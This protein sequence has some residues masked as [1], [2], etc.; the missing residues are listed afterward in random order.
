MWLFSGVAESGTSVIGCASDAASVSVGGAAPDEIC[1]ADN[2]D[3]IELRTEKGAG[4]DVFETARFLFVRT[5][6]DGDSG[7]LDTVKVKTQLPTTLPDREFL[8][9][10]NPGSLVSPNPIVIGQK[11]SIS[12][13]LQNKDVIFVV[14]G[15][16][17]HDVVIDTRPSLPGYN[18][19]NVVVVADR[20]D[21]L[22]ITASGYNGRSGRDAKELLALKAAS[23]DSSVPRGIADKFMSRMAAAPAITSLMFDQK[24]DM[25]NYA[26][27]GLQ[28][29]AGETP[30]GGSGTYAYEVLKGGTGTADIDIPVTAFKKE[31]SKRTYCTRDAE[32][33]IRQQCE[34]EAEYSFRALCEIT[35]ET[36]DV[37]VMK[38]DR[39]T[40]ER[41]VCGTDVVN[42]IRRKIVRTAYITA[43]IPGVKSFSG[44]VS[45]EVP[46]ADTWKIYRPYDA[47]KDVGGN[48]AVPIVEAGI[49]WVS[50]FWYQSASIG[51]GSTIP[52]ASS[53]S[54]GNDYNTATGD[55]TNWTNYPAD[56]GSTP[57]ASKLLLVPRTYTKTESGGG[58][59]YTPP[60]G[61]IT[62]QESLY[63]FFSNSASN[64]V[65][66]YNGS[67]ATD[68]GRTQTGCAKLLDISSIKLVAGDILSTKIAGNTALKLAGATDYSRAL[69]Y[70][71]SFDAKDIG[72]SNADL[73]KAVVTVTSCSSYEVVEAIIG[74]NPTRSGWANKNKAQSAT[75]SVGRIIGLETFFQYDVA[76]SCYVSDPNSPPD[77]LMSSYGVS[78]ANDLSVSS[79]NSS[80]WHKGMSTGSAP[81][82]FTTPSPYD[83]AKN[84]PLSKAGFDIAK[85]FVPPPGYP[86]AT[87]DA[88]A[89]LQDFCVPLTNFAPSGNL[90]G[91]R[92]ANETSAVQTFR[93]VILPVYQTDPVTGVASPSSSQKRTCPG[94]VRLD[95]WVAAV[96]R[97]SC[98]G[99]TDN[100]II[101]SDWSSTDS[102]DNWQTWTEKNGGFIPPVTTDNTY[103]KIASITET[104]YDDMPSVYTNWSHETDNALF[105]TDSSTGVN[106]PSDNNFP[107]IDQAYDSDGVAISSVKARSYPGWA[108]ESK[109]KTSTNTIL[110]PETF[111]PFGG[112]PDEAKKKWCNAPAYVSVD[113]KL[114]K[115]FGAKGALIDPPRHVFSFDLVPVTGGDIGSPSRGTPVSYTG[116]EITGVVASGSAGAQEGFYATDSIFGGA[117]S[118]AALDFKN[119]DSATLAWRAKMF[120]IANYPL[121]RRAISEPCG[122]GKVFNQF[123][124]YCH[125]VS[126]YMVAGSRGV[127]IYDENRT[128]A[129]NAFRFTYDSQSMAGNRPILSSTSGGTTTTKTK[130]HLC[131]NGVGGSTN[132]TA[133]M[134]LPSGPE[135]WWFLGLF[136]PLSVMTN[137]LEA[138]L[139]K[140]WA[141]RPES[142]GKTVASP[143]FALTYADIF[144]SS[145]QQTMRILAVPQ[146]RLAANEVD[147]SPTS[148][149]PKLP[150]ESIFLQIDFLPDAG[151]TFVKPNIAIVRRT[152]DVGGVTTT[153]SLLDQSGIQT[154]Q[155]TVEADGKLTL[156]LGNTSSALYYKIENISSTIVA[157]MRS[158]TGKE[159][160]TF[161]TLSAPQT[162]NRQDDWNLS[163]RTV[164]GYSAPLSWK[165]SIF[166]TKTAAT[167]SVSNPPPSC[168]LENL[169]DGEFKVEVPLQTITNGGTNKSCLVPGNYCAMTDEELSLFT[170]SKTSSKELIATRPAISQFTPWSHELTSAW[171][172][173]QAFNTQSDFGD[174]TPTESSYGSSVPDCS[175]FESP[176]D[177]YLDKNF[178]TMPRATDP[179]KTFETRADGKTFDLYIGPAGTASNPTGNP[180]GQTPLFKVASNA[181][182][183][184]SDACVEWDNINASRCV[185]FDSTFSSTAPAGATL[186]FGGLPGS[187]RRVFVETKTRL[188]QNCTYFD[189][190]NANQCYFKDQSVTGGSCP[191]GTSLSGT[192]CSGAAAKGTPVTARC[193]TSSCIFP[194]NR[195][196]YQVDSSVAVNGEA[197]EDGSNG[198]S[199]T[200]FCRDCPS[201]TSENPG[202]GAQRANT[203]WTGAGLGGRGTTPVGSARSLT[204][205]CVSSDNNNINP[206]FQ[207]RNLWSQPFVPGAS[208]QNGRNGLPGSGVTTYKDLT[209]EVIWQI[210]QPDFWFGSDQ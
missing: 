5:H 142:F 113:G 116:V 48:P 129:Q 65:S 29:A 24:L 202:S 143:G 166:T 2:E 172:K 107:G 191:A 164:T 41:A 209:P 136:R 132:C 57:R 174:W 17:V 120:D 1:K 121:L 50:P 151:E 199:I 19:G 186:A 183:R 77:W 139:Q 161:R 20:L 156:I 128:L 104:R 45:R 64:D 196:T 157:G 105:V 38:K 31:E 7:N 11:A 30:V 208:G 56:F 96:T 190:A 108:R 131:L 8:Q 86:S 100:G 83:A 118:K 94:G 6:G 162:R 188:S 27:A 210:S 160:L 37:T 22:A 91:T 148:Q 36:R 49:N 171:A 125:D 89:N 178:A 80:L 187:W 73:K 195:Q 53:L 97:P 59:D 180:N 74:S 46:M 106:F 90:A 3:G 75:C 95:R 150:V 14:D 126:S 181:D 58:V 159:K 138:S 153:E 52:V 189:P 78:Q 122:A 167:T 205:T 16:P 13:G 51:S 47:N 68:A 133:S 35:P 201:L 163:P 33:K 79:L 102:A 134:D 140:Q 69:D 10:Q 168:S 111:I 182:L 114:A 173:D 165:S 44:L 93:S 169:A 63:G 42:Q 200:V 192:M 55:L 130:Y 124:G 40:W 193:S 87:F 177:K 198:G 98:P 82:P 144:S 109:L 135:R 28:C 71:R 67:G 72:F 176:D 119:T 110:A 194:T 179:A 54:P 34:A 152:A 137:G 26:D 207:V 101:H 18:A 197:G 145:S 184:Q 99:G 158:T 92:S 204:L 39:V 21:S 185:K 70:L 170:K 154:N 115:G 23:G 76:G 146:S 206:I 103:S 66:V 147:L 61:P 62:D 88:S 12:P 112:T 60:T 127:R 25:E 43:T 117:R 149:N 4:E 84:G 175:V 9:R 32:Y 141:L 203:Y 15:A 85:D 123:L 155:I 81:G